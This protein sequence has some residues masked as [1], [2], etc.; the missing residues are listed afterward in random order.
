MSRMLVTGGTGFIGSNLA[1][2]LESQGHTVVVA[3][4]TTEGRA[5]NL[6]GFRGEVIAM[7]AA[8]PWKI[9]GKFD[10]VFHQAAL[11]DP[12]YSNDEEILHKN[13]TGFEEA[14]RFS[15][16]QGARLIYASTAGLYGHGPVPMREDQEVELLTAYGRSK[17]LMD[18]RARR[19]F[20]ETPVGLVGLRYFNVFGPREA[21]KGRPASMIYHLGK[22]IRE[23]GEARIFEFGEQVRDH[24]YVKDA[25]TANLCAWQAPR[26]GIFNVGTGI[27]TSFKDLVTVLNRVLGTK[28]PTVYFKMPYDPATY[29]ANTI[30]ETSQAVR[31]LG[32]QSR[33]SLEAGITDYFKWLGWI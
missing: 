3:D 28:A 8:L 16:A 11:T 20:E 6:Q 25:V 13:T 12:R 24:I 19:L 27:G 21:G 2:T 23:T 26:S 31:G 15:R 18:E 7:D 17:W 9:P 33:F 5:A 4:L 22:Q 14:I 29:Q 30:A 1:L 10:A 32:F